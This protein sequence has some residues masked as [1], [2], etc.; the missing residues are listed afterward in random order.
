MAVA[1]VGAWARACV[2]K[3]HLHWEPAQRTQRRPNTKAASETT[4]MA[5]RVALWPN[6]KPFSMPWHPGF[7]AVEPV[8]R[9]VGRWRGRH[10]GQI[11]RRRRDASVGPRAQIRR[12]LLVGMA[13]LALCP[14]TDPYPESRSRAVNR[15]DEVNPAVSVLCRAMGLVVAV[16]RVIGQVLGH[17]LIGVEPYLRKAAGVGLLFGLV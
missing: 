15:L 6:E 7:G 2:D 12:A 9:S 1:Y 10:P 11:R 17:C 4:R 16:S 8:G 3:L 13:S 14:Q 5:R